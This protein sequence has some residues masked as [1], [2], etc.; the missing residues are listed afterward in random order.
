ME[1]TDIRSFIKSLG[2]AVPDDE[3]FLK[4]SK[5]TP[6]Y[7]ENKELYIINYE[8]GMLLYSIVAK[9]KPLNIL[10]IGTAKGYSA[11]C[12][13]WAMDDYDIPGTIHTIDP[14]LDTKF[15][16]VIDGKVNILSAPQLWDKIASDRWLSKIKPFSGY[17]GEVVDK[18]KFPKIDFAYIDG[19]HVFEA[20]EHDFYAFLDIASDNFRV[21]FDDYALSD[22][23]TKLIDDNVSK[24]FDGVLIK[25]NLKQQ[26][27]QLGLENSSKHNL[28]HAMCWFEQASLKK[29][30]HQV[31]PKDKIDHVLKKYRRFEKRWML[32]QKINQKFPA[33]RNIRF[34]KY[35]HK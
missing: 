30:L 18:F 28:F 33:L 13:A 25:T 12:M 9:Y 4:L 22:G 23:V 34:S 5:L 21:L 3:E 19:H 15:E 10:E 26:Y 31:Y 24:N 20:V 16:I 27:E 35:F 1:T 8:R 17:S 14:T 6:M 32:R 29:P 2:V 11:L 7:P